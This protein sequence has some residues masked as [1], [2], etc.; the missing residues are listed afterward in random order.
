MTAK[1]H[2][3]SI[4]Y[5]AMFIAL[6]TVCSWISIPVG[7]PFTLQTFAMFVTIGLIGTKRGTISIALYV[8]LGAVGVPVFSGF[9]GG[10]STLLGPTGGYIIGFVIGGFV[11]GIIIDLFGKKKDV[12]L[13]ACAMLAGLLVCYA[14]GT[15]WFM[16]VYA[17]NGSAIV[18]T[19]ALAL[20][21]VPFIIPDCLK[22]ALAIFLTRT[23]CRYTQ[24]S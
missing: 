9:K 3:I 5:M 8:L 23:L 6:I 18:L 14:F 22:I 15:A 2:T 19:S 24:L 17:Q 7:I 21:V 4:V 10:F 11:T 20:C 1:A 16:V 13:L 12:I